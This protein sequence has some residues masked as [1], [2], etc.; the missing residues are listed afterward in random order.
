[1]IE[2]SRLTKIFTGVLAT[3]VCVTTISFADLGS[4][5]SVA[6]QC[7]AAEPAESSIEIERFTA[8]RDNTIDIN[9]YTYTLVPDI[10]TD[11]ER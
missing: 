3:V 7:P 11:P 4:A 8:G 6:L 10:N 5:S 2:I 1:M 9:D